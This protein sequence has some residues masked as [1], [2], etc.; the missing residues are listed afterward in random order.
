MLRITRGD[1][2]RDFQI[3]ED[4]IPLMQDELDNVSTILYIIIETTRYDAPSLQPTYDAIGMALGSS[5]RS[6]R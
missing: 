3:P 6:N 4:D 2:F 5:R 1:E